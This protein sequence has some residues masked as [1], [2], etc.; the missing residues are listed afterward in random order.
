M[1]A[2]IE[3]RGAK[4]SYLLEEDNDPTEGQEWL[5][6]NTGGCLG[7]SW[8]MG[9]AYKHQRNNTDSGASE[10]KSRRDWVAT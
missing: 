10:K 2:L 3:H 6:E 4:P 1:Q 8:K 5:G 7:A 9:R